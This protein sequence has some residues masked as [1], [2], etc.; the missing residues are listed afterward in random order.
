MSAEIFFQCESLVFL[1]VFWVLF[2]FL[3]GVCGSVFVGLAC[4]CMLFSVKFHVV[5]REVGMLPVSGGLDVGL[6]VA[7]C[8]S[9]AV[10]AWHALHGRSC[11]HSAVEP[12]IRYCQRL[13]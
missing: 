6:K 13:L 8:F 1:F 7:A 5:K 11:L 2:L 4:A 9:E 12:E 3:Y 10:S